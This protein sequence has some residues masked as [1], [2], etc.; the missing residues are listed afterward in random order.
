[1]DDRI[2]VV[3][4]FHPG[5]EPAVPETAEVTWN[6]GWLHKRKFLRASGSYLE[7]L[8]GPERRAELGFWGEWEAESRAA[9][10]ESPVPGGPGWIHNPF[11]DPLPAGD[12]AQNTDPF[13]FGG[14]FIYS[15]CQQ[16]RRGRPAQLASLLPGSVV[17]FGSGL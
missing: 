14:D 8:R 4:L 1:M 15:N 12:W 2:C 13:V 16:H 5:G 6:T 11:F 10:V 3:Q 9:R 7:T 17:L